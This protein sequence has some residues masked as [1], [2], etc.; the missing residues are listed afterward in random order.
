MD[1]RRPDDR[2]VPGYR[3][4]RTARLVCRTGSLVSEHAGQERFCEIEG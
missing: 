1:G 2:E 4:R 3:T